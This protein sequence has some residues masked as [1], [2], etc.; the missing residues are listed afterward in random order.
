MSLQII[1]YIDFESQLLIYGLAV[2]TNYTLGQAFL[3][4]C[5]TSLRACGDHITHQINRQ[6]F[7]T[8]SVDLLV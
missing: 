2:Y 4:I 8:K 1:F 5:N 7:C 6:L 3:G